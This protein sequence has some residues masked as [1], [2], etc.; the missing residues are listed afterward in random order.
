MRVSRFIIANASDG[1]LLG[2]SQFHKKEG[3]CLNYL[4]AMRDS[5]Q[6]VA[7]ALTAGAGGFFRAGRH[8]LRTQLTKAVSP[9]ERDSVSGWK[10]APGDRK[11]SPSRLFQQLNLFPYSFGLLPSGANPFL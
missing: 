7:R 4:W 2:S 5:C 10:R 9:I 1:T 3:T 8:W 11:T 6:R